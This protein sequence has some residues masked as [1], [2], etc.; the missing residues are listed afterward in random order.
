M[1]R[2]SYAE[3]RCLAVV[4]EVCGQSQLLAAVRAQGWHGQTCS[5]TVPKVG[6]LALRLRS[7]D[8]HTRHKPTRSTT[9]ENTQRHKVKHNSK[10]TVTNTGQK[11]G[12]TRDTNAT[13][14]LNP[15]GIR[16]T[17]SLG[18][19][20][21]QQRSGGEGKMALQSLRCKEVTCSCEVANIWTAAL[22]K[23]ALKSG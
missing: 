4:W 15:H 16:I 17:N 23:E 13:R 6:A 1:G 18:N 2:S 14:M 21:S 19:S 8:I 22:Q 12:G 11:E 9:G 20:L 5:S 3:L 10:L 7:S